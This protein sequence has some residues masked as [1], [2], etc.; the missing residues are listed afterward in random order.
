MWYIIITLFV[1]IVA[2]LGYKKKWTGIFITL[3]LLFL[4]MFRG[5]NVGHDTK[6]YIDLHSIYLKAV[7]G[8]DISE[9]RVTTETYGIRTELITQ[10]LNDLVYYNDLPPRFI[11]YFYSIVTIAFLFYA[12]K[13]FRVNIALGM[14]FYVLMGL[15]FFSLTA[16]RQMAAISIVLFGISYIQEASIKK[17]FF[18][19]FV[20]MASLIHASAIFFV[21]LYFLKYLKAQKSVFVSVAAIICLFFFIFPIDIMGLVY[22]VVGMDYITRYRGG[23]DSHTMHIFKTF[24]SLFVF[25]FY[26]YWVN[27]NKKMRTELF[28]NLYLVALILLASFSPY[29][30]LIRRAVFYVSIFICV[31]LSKEMEKHQFEKKQDMRLLTISFVL[32]ETYFA[33]DWLSMLE[34]DYYLMF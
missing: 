4:S 33:K 9:E 15:Y 19:L 18:F 30:V 27:L 31:Y 10:K 14:M 13:R 12:L 2:L 20:S 7:G 24:S 17:Y 22:K 6:N 21:W 16:A 3:L 23:Y 29:S 34:S 5:E 32:F 28:D 25:Y 8:I 1:S 11:L 26:F